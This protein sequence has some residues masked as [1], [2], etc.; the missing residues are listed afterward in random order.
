MVYYSLQVLAYRKK[1]KPLKLLQKI[2]DDKGLS[3]LGGSKRVGEKFTLTLNDVLSHQRYYDVL[4]KTSPK[5]LIERQIVLHHTRG[6]G[7][8]TDLARA[9]ATKDIQLL[10]GVVNANVEKLENIVKGTAKTPGRKLTVDEITKL[11]NYGAKIVDFDGKIVGGSKL[12]VQNSKLK[13]LKIEKPLPNLDLSK[14]QKP[15]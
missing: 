10:T 15:D 1:L 14:Y 7:A 9:A 3:Q 12:V 4:S 13:D 5:A 8:G 6:V 11:K 2:L